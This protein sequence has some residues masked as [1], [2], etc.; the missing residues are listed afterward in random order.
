MAVE[1]F[2]DVIEA[3]FTKMQ[4]RYGA[5][6]LRQWEGVDMNLVKSD[7]GNEL[8]GF[9]RNL[10]PLR[11]ALRNLP[12][13]CPNVSQFRAIANCCPLPEFKQLEAPRASEK[14]VAEQ[15]AK[16]TDL[17]AAMTPRNDPKEWAKVIVK[18]HEM[19]DRIRPLVLLFARQAL[20]MEGKQKWQ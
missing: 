12:D 8:S 14:V 10:E 20:G 5:T 18:R 7:W 11:Y 1:T 2:T 6:W 4:V 19:G 16:Q 13:R 3:I 17:K 9:A 15:I